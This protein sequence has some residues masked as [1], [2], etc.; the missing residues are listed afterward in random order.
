MYRC[1]CL[2]VYIDIY[3]DICAAGGASARLIPLLPVKRSTGHTH[4]HTHTHTDREQH[5]R[6]RHTRT[7]QEQHPKPPNE[8]LP[9]MLNNARREEGDRTA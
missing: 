2:C 1:V 7:R 5:P 8:H 6:H 9:Q 3:I 4:T